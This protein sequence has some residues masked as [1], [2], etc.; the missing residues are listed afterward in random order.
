MHA[1]GNLV[2]LCLVLHL[3]IQGLSDLVAQSWL[4]WPPGSHMSPKCRLKSCVVSFFTPSPSTFLL[5]PEGTR[6]VVYSQFPFF[7]LTTLI[8]KGQHSCT[9]WKL[10]LELFNL[11]QPPMT[12]QELWSCRELT[13][14]DL[15][16]SGGWRALQLKYWWGLF[17][18]TWLPG[19]SCTSTCA[20]LS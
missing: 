7:S 3:D 9:A 13:D 8:W 19:I 16:P 1:K 14:C 15:A 12:S 18:T 6:R 5:P 11:A 20:V 4:C 17:R 10:T 2:F